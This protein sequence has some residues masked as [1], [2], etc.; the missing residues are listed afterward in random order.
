MSSSSESPAPRSWSKSS[1]GERI[2]HICKLRGWSL[3]RLA[4]EAGMASGPMSRLSRRPEHI[5]A[6][7]ETLIRIAD[8]ARV[9]PMWLIAGQGPVERIVRGSLRAH[10][11]WPTAL[12]EARKRQLGIPEEYWSLVGDVVLQVPNVD[13]QLVV[14]LVRELYSAAQRKDVEPAAAGASGGSR[15][16]RR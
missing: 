2:E 4:E 12:A 14:G 16:A 9:Q 13:W 7:P 8:A 1:L 10:P 3:R 11:E 15:R 6:S 5:A